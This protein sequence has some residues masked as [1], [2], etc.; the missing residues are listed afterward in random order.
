[1]ARAQTPNTK[2]GNTHVV[3][4]AALQRSVRAAIRLRHSLAADAELAERLPKILESFD[5]TVLA[6]E[7]FSIDVGEL[8]DPPAPIK[9]KLTKARA[10]KAAP[11]G[12]RS[13]KR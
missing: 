8:L 9:P 2:L 11:A 6:G 1:M 5:A 13:V 4:R 10:S 3:A 12:R 7:S